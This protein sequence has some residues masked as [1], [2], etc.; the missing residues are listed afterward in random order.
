MAEVV[1]LDGKKVD[2]IIPRTDRPE[3]VL[4]RL[5]SEIKDGSAKIDRLIVIVE[6]QIGDREKHY[7]TRTSLATTSEAVALTVIGTRMLI[8]GIFDI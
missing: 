8:D 1:G 7:F 6:G 5:L 2:G 3:D 4:G